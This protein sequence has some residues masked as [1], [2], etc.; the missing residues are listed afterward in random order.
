MNVVSVKGFAVFAVLG[1]VLGYGVTK[2]S[3]ADTRQN[4]RGWARAH[5]GMTAPVATC[6]RVDGVDLC[7]VR[8]GAVA[9]R[10]VCMERG[11]SGTTCVEPPAR[12]EPAAPVAPVSNIDVR[13]R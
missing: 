4:A 13:V 3:E 2:A 11:C 7:T 12:V 8:Q 6:E 5:L 10:L 9:R 1:A